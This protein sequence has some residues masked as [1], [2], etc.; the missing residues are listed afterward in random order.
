MNNL[1]VERSLNDCQAELQSVKDSLDALGSTHVVVPFLTKYAVIRACG[2]IEQSFKSV[3]ADYCSQGASRQVGRFLDRRVRNS[4]AN[5]SWE[6]M[7]RFLK[8]FDENWHKT[9]KASVDSHINK[10]KIMTSLQSL[11]DA[12][13]VFAHGGNPSGSIADVLQY[14][15]HGRSLIEVLD[16][17]IK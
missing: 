14:F 12:R 1:G 2:T 3:I 16:D 15:A 6:I 9:F 13:N 8:D 17:V 5:P 11:V 10:D 4:P 7:C